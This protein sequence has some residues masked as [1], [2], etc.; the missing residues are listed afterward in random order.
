MVMFFL[1]LALVFVVLLVRSDTCQESM[2][3]AG[4]AGNLIES[5]GATS[6]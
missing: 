2:Q 1:I 6:I 5:V 4:E 3:D